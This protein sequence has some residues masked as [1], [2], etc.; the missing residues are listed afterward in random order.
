MKT[1]Y[2][3]L[4]FLFG[5]LFSC[6]RDKSSQIIDFYPQNDRIWLGPE[7]WAN[8]LQ[9]WHVKNGRI[10]CTETTLPLRTAHVLT[11]QLKIGD[12]YL[13]MNVDFGIDGDLSG[14]PEESFSGFML[15]A[16]GKELDYRAASLIHHGY[17]KNGGLI[18][19]VNK[20]G[21]IIC[22]YND[23]DLKLLNPVLSHG[24]R[25]TRESGE[26]LELSVK[27]TLHQDRYYLSASVKNM[28]TGE[29]MKESH[30]ENIDPKYLVGNIALVSHC[31]KPKE[32]EGSPV[33]WFNNLKI[34]GSKI[35][36]NKRNAL[37]PIISSMFTVSRGVL[38]M[39]A[40]MAPLGDK[41]QNEVYLEID[42]EGTGS[43]ERINNAEIIKPGWTATFVI[44]GW[45]YEKDIPYRLVYNLDRDRFFYD[46][47]IPKD[48]KEK[49][50]ITVA[51]FSCQSQTFG[52]IREHFDFDSEH[53]WFPHPWMKKN[54]MASNPDILAFVGDQV[55][56]ARP[57]KVDNSGNYSSFLDYM[58]KWYLFCWA[59]RDLM[60]NI[61]TI[62][63]PDDHDV[64]QG[65]LWGAGGKQ[66]DG[67]VNGKLPNKPDIAKIQ[68]SGGYFMPPGFVRMVERTQTSQLP[69]P[70]YK[71]KI[72]QGLT[73]Y[74][75]DLL[76][77]G[78]S[79]AVL[80]DRK[81]KIGPRDLVSKE[82]INPC[83]Y[84]QPELTLL[85][86]K[87]L[88]FLNKWSAD[89]EGTW[90]KVAI[91]Q[92]IFANAHTEELY[93]N[94][95]SHRGIIPVGGY[96]MYRDFDTNGW[97]KTGRD[98]ALDALRKGFALNI[99][100]D[101]HL[102][103]IIHMG[104]DEWEDASFSLCTPSIANLYPRRWFP[105]YKGENHIEGMPDYTGR[106]IDPFG[107]KM[108]VWAAANPYQTDKKPKNLNEWATGFALA[109]LNKKTQQIE[110]EC[111]PHYS[112]PSDPESEQFP[113]WPMTIDMEENYGRK[114]VAW[115]PEV[116]V[117]GLD[118]PPVI[119]VTDQESGEIVYTLRIKRNSYQPKVFKEGIYSI[120]VGEPGTDKM[121][122]LTDI[123]SS[124]N[125]S[126][127]GIALT[128]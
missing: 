73:T 10:E 122:I 23:K 112:C 68:Y 99:G 32:Q 106:Y 83:D 8:R 87:Q 25:I 97:P 5:L 92:T 29:V 35:V 49:E 18:I 127:E 77:G 101:Q 118:D 15:G 126:I 80:E 116:R 117:S 105:R 67:L 55:Y 64:Y 50:E 120:K 13:L 22:Y 28:S 39:T 113:G 69:D 90:M 33:F 44:S 4:I 7:L 81:F 88:E 109:K 119:Q 38:K 52:R 121:K 3:F 47:L 43:W 98:K 76:W 37:G 114:A 61:P 104:I 60:R 107:N 6:T 89:W 111:W 86:D 123:K 16:G 26:K 9:D 75:T 103:T 66:C 85:G 93:R 34:S 125:P 96:E 56:E 91:S 63:M 94:P 45:N 100:G 74:Y 46:G 70:Y 24:K 65:N 53:I 48:P 42:K 20:V 27:I 54:V 78:V 40:Q 51:A 82:S 31:S 58:Y 19:G 30:W 102:A 21:D 110:M 57:T 84:D 79:F 11:R 62:C 115:L 108:T 36:Y 71:G 72:K 95:P 12:G 14:I 17:G 59:H 124:R 2:L 128:Y 1:K 41:D